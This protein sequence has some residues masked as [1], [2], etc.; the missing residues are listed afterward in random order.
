MG[1]GFARA[2]QCLTTSHTII[3]N[4]E[5][6]NNITIMGKLTIFLDQV[7][8]LHDHHLIGRSEPFVVFRLEK[9]GTF[10][11]YG[12]KKSTKKL[13]GNH[14]VYHETFVFDNIPDTLQGLELKIKVMGDDDPALDDK[15]GA[16]TIHLDKLGLTSTP[17]A[18]KADVEHHLIGKDA[19]A[20]LKI[21]FQI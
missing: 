8:D 3:S 13:G 17:T 5:D 20:H 7:T 12:T 4:I 15:L 14:V 18:V 19:L 11:D 6:N 1:F 9:D 10:L 16:G 21:S 2:R